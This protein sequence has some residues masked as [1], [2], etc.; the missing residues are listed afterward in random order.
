MK[1]AFYSLIIWLNVFSTVCFATPQ[2]LDDKN[3]KMYAKQWQKIDS[4]ENKG[5]Y[6][7]ALEEVGR[8]F[9][10]ASDNADHN[11]VIKAVLY[12]LKYNSYL[13][14]DDYVIGINKLEGTIERVPSPSKEIFHSILA[15]VY[16][17]YY[18]ANSWKFSNRTSV[19]GVDLKDIR[20]WDLKRIAEKVRYHYTQSLNNDQYAK[21]ASITEF[22]TIIS[23]DKSTLAIRPTLYDFLAHRALDFFKSNTFELGGSA[24]TYVID[25][26]AYFGTNENFVKLNAISEDSLNTR[27]LAIQVYRLLTD[28]HLQ[29]KNSEPLFHIALER[30][31]YVRE[32]GAMPEKDDDYYRAVS[33]LA[34]AYKTEPFAAEAFYEQAKYHAERAAGYMTGSESPL[35][36]ERKI[37]FEICQ[38]TI[39]K[40]PESF[41]AKQCLSLQS[42]LLQKQLGVNAEEAVIPNKTAKILLDYRNLE[43]AYFKIVAFDPSKNDRERY[44]TEKLKAELAKRKPV[45]K[46][47]L[48]LTDP[49]DYN[50][51]SIELMLPALESGMYFLVFSTNADYGGENEAFTYQPFW[52]TDL[53]YQSRSKDG[54]NDVLVSSRSTGLPV[55]GASVG[56][57]YEKYNYTLNRYDKKTVGKFTTGA[58]GKIQFA[59][60]PDYR[61]YEITIDYEGENYR[62][63]NQIYNY[64]YNKGSGN[65][66]ITSLFTDRKIYRPGQSIFYKGII[67]EAQ[68]KE[69]KLKKSYVSDVYFYDVNGQEVA[70]T[71][72][73]T[74]QFGS[75]QGEFKAPFGVLTGAMR[76]VS[77]NGSNT[78]GSTTIRVEEYKRP[79]FNI[80]MNP[81]EGEF[82]VNDTITATGVAQ[83]YAGN[84]IDGA[85]VTYRVVRSVSYNNYWYW[86]YRPAEPKEITQGTLVT[87][88]NGAFEI[89]F[90]AI[91]DRES[92]PKDL[93]IF[94]Y[95]VYVDVTDINGE[96]HS[97]S[98]T[99]V[100]GYQSMQLGNNLSADMNNATNFT[101]RI[102]S[103]NLNGQPVNAKGQVSIHQ[104]QMPTEALYGRKWKQPDM[105]NWTEAE[106]KALFPK[107]VYKNEDEPQ[108]WS[109]KSTVFEASFNTEVSDSL[110]INDFK[111]WQPGMYK[112]EA[113][114]L[115]KN[116][117]EVKDMRYFTIF[118]PNSTKSPATDLVWVKPLKLTAEPGEK[119][120][121]LL[122][123]LENDVLIHYDLEANGNLLESKTLK[124]SNEQQK[125]S[126]DVKETFRGNFAIHFTAIRNNKKVQE[127][128]NITVPY[129]NKQLDVRFS[130]F[131]NKLLPGAAEEWIVTIKNKYGEKEQAELLA[132]LY[133]ASL[134]PLY[135]PNSF[136]MNIY[137]T[138]YG[139]RAW[140]G[141]V[142]FGNGYSQNS[143]YYWNKTVGMPSRS[144][145]Y[146][147]YFGWQAYYYPG[148]YGGYG[149]NYALDDGIAEEMMEVDAVKASGSTTTRNKKSVEREAPSGEFKA[150]KDE[151]MT[152]N[153]PVTDN[154]NKENT[155]NS[156]NEDLSAVKARTNFNETAFFFPQLTTD[157]E[158]N[159]S[160]KFTIPE[161]LTKWRFL[162]LAHT[163]D[164]KIGY[165]QEEIITQKELMVVPNMPRFLRENDAITLSAKISNISEQDLSGQAQLVLID[166]FTEQPVSAKFNLQNA[167]KSFSANKGQSTVVSWTVKVPY[168]LGAVK[169][170]IVASA[171]SFSDGE[172][173]VL[174]IL[175]NRML[176]TE[177]L[178]MPIRGNQTKNFSFDKLKNANSS[179][180][181]RHHRF[182]LE[183]TSNPA[184]YAIQAMPYM[185]EYP[186]ECAEQVFT[187]YYSNAIASHIM[188][189]NPKIKQVVDAWANESPEAFLSNLQ[190]NQELKAVMLEETPWVLNAKNE[191]QSKRNLA[192]LLDMNRMTKELEI[193]LGKTIK[194]QSSNGGW[195]WFPGMR[196]SRYITQHI[197]TGMGHLDH[198]GIKNVR[199]DSKTWKM[200]KKAV[201]YLDKQIVN[202]F[203]N[204]KRYDPD[205]LKN[206]HIG[207]LQVQYLYARSYFPEIN[208]DGATQTAVAYYKDQATKFWLQFNIYAEGM[209]ALAA[210]RFEMNTLATD[211]VKSL[212]DRAIQSEE[213]G[214]YWKDYTVG[215]YWYQAPVETQ[216]LMIEMFNDITNDQQVVDELKVWLLKQKQTTSWKTTKQ[217]TEAVFA[218]LLT[219]SD[220][221]S[222]DELVE[223]TLG[224]KKIQYVD[225]ATAKNSTDPYEVNAEAG[226]GYFKTAWEGEAVKARMGD[227]KVQ[228]KDKGIAWGAAYWQYF[229]DIDKI[230]YA[231]TN[232]KLKKDLFLVAVTDNGEQLEPITAENK[233]KIGKKVRVRIELRTDRNLEYVHL[234]DM[235]AAG[236]EPI[237]VLSRYRYQDGLG[238]YQSTKDV[239]THFFFDYIPKGTY[240]FE[241]DL[242]VQHNGDFSNGIATIQCMYAPEFTSHSDGIRVKV[243]D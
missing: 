9:L 86:W 98:Q 135:T 122:A 27:F 206:Q 38:K 29:N 233:L 54:K 84:K 178:P 3:D 170:K 89:N 191:E 87:D 159:V 88:E 67:Y 150:D 28:F 48:A 61:S 119:V 113:T 21:Q 226:T 143:N 190:K 62:P 147:R 133:D 41:G 201:G 131:R 37:A 63:D 144:Y 91:P 198:L 25:Q 66:V 215:Y 106:F 138:F 53:T 78:N 219:G 186:H 208:L 174:P 24:D 105:Q 213:M 185:M 176:V 39:E 68:G 42:A 81:V 235:R 104:L 127:S 79:K 172:E 96:T 93:P 129:T 83:A 222:S 155:E 33:R 17:G 204:A 1:T 152:N 188:G 221:L 126:F 58:D 203:E 13:K 31:K 217:T 72:V 207:Y 76:I 125:L 202:D 40:Y 32:K 211:I 85:A 26:T 59:N 7:M 99:I 239:A 90:E 95:T 55:Q 192:V 164:L 243:L 115:D 171:A 47:Q 56:V 101:L 124:L 238:Y 50:P 175:S 5:L 2:S 216:A 118:N 242:R 180:T 74:N 70:K 18:S 228:K 52:V 182:T 123:T 112:Y 166:P 19:V 151:S 121:I 148:Y 128:V 162:G 179:S 156:G 210:H 160:I 169:Y 60:V 214:M 223:I 100:A 15:E 49:K 187:R 80:E 212:K 35:K 234:K 227:I 69:R 34:E 237:D 139:Q 142:D 199:N 75:F 10:T 130:T 149:R 107:Q 241:Y 183:F 136:Y 116:G 220:L 30:F 231:E 57:F 137:Q 65:R 181:L 46:K 12:E 157:K 97:T 132:T 232:L 194:S 196:E 71:S 64:T 224:D 117:V 158:G 229:E 209:I 20:T 108:N 11:Q 36:D 77:R 154:S 200:V 225:K 82:K 8:L 168:E 173:N 43:M 177:S 22:E 197:V 6:N 230:T 165:L 120:E 146:L 153:A 16:W 109:V 218:L 51:H 195:P 134:D 236:F 114:A 4:L 94:S 193:A 103:A 140:G 167:Q 161:S 111:S 14:E 102:S 145:P 45:Y 240:V 110:P 141:A 92:N 184:W 205:Y 23:A 44:T 163:E 189:S 73:K